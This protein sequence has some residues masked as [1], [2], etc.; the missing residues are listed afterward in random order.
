M[1]RRTRQPNNQLSMLEPR[2][3]TAPCVPA[4][5]KSVDDWRASFY[6]G[7]SETTRARSH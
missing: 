7:V 1:P 6:Q 3:K 2:L 5:R 4:A